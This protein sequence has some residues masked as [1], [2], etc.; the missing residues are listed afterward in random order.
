MDLMVYYFH[1]ERKTTMNIN[2]YPDLP[3]REW[4]DKVLPPPYGPIILEGESVP[5]HLNKKNG[6]LKD[7]SIFKE[8]PRYYNPDIEVS[9]IGRVKYKGK[10]S[11]QIYDDE[12]GVLYIKTSNTRHPREDVHRLVALPW[13]NYDGQDYCAIHHIDN[14]GYNN[15]MENLLI[16]TPAQ[17]EIIHIKGIWKHGGI[18]MEF[19]ENKFTIYNNSILYKG[20]FSFTDDNIKK[21]ANTHLNLFY[22]DKKITLSHQNIKRIKRLNGFQDNELNGDWERSEYKLNVLKNI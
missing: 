18:F 8:F 3:L 16:V 20:T 5:I 13:F 12:R 1:K 2:K 7:E 6:L 22:K 17:H 9:N 19:Y 15:R 14:N 4:Q 11:D 21:S 10:F